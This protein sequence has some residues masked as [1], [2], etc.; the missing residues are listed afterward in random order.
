MTK[1]HYL[2]LYIGDSISQLDKK[3]RRFVV[4]SE[5]PITENYRFKGK[6]VARAEKA[7]YELGHD[8]YNWANPIRNV[9]SNLFPSFVRI[10]VDDCRTMFPDNRI[11]NYPVEESS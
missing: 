11:V 4:Q 6:V 10:P 2:Y 1:P 8:S 7:S 9:A 5:N 3:K